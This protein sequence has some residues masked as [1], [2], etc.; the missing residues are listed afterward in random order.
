MKSATY[1]L[2]G[3]CYYVSPKA[4]TKCPGCLGYD[5]IQFAGFIYEKYD[6]VIVKTEKEMNETMPG[7]A[8]FLNYDELDPGYDPDMIKYGGK[9]TFV[10]SS[11]GDWIDLD[12]DKG[13]WS[14]SPFWVKPL[15]HKTVRELKSCLKD[16]L[17][18]I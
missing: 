12:I 16:D 3:D 15:E 14:W 2:C 1:S 6:R 7:K 4:V 11:V 17:F 10:Y 5:L 9:E 13:E 18:D 8:N